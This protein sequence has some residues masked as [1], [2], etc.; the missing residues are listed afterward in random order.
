M[1][2]L[3]EIRIPTYKRPVL[4]QRNLE[5]LIQQTYSN[6][7]ALIFDDSPSQDARQVVENINDPR[8]IYRP[9]P[10]NLGC[11]KNLDQAFSEKQH[12]GGCYA[13]VIEDDN[14]IL[15][16]FLESNIK[17]LSNSNLRVLLR[18]QVIMVDR[19]FGEPSD[20]GQ[21]TRGAIFGT[22]DAVLSPLMVHA[23]MFFG[24]GLSNG[25]IFWKISPEVNF[26]VGNRSEHSPMQEYLRSLQLKESV[27][28][29]ADPLAVFSLPENGSTTRESLSNR[30]F[31]RGKME[32]ISFLL[33]KYGYLIT[34]C[35][36]GIA[37]TDKKLIQHY[38]RTLCYCSQSPIVAWR[39]M[40][41]SGLLLWVKGMLVFKTIKTPIQI[42]YE[43]H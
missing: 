20:T 9:N 3:I 38:K 29:A 16:Q 23:A 4:L 35:A 37:K 30:Q 31:N 26:V 18:N 15:P 7:V 41:M 12:A 34:E 28:Y 1:S 36:F 10:R 32:I 8:I 27:F 42:K 21:T 40:K 11:S 33:Q 24:T 25:G 5:H 19:D 17:K 13:C 6:W 39:E 2:N 14:W 43:K 22:K